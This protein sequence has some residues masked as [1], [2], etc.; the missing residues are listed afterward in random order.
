MSFTIVQWFVLV[1]S[2]LALVK[3][4][5]VFFN[6]KAWL[7]LVGHIYGK[8]SH[9]TIVVEL[10]LA[11]GLLLYLL[12]EMTIVQIMGAIIFGALL[13]GI[14]FAAFGKETLAF[15]NKILRTKGA[16]HKAIISI[17][18]WLALTIWA[19]VSLF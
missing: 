16:V 8:A 9:V 1:F 10:I 18:I 3:I 17:V 11:L 14:T 6:P 13:S 19:L 7:K 4:L 15:G 12:K 5:F 2:I